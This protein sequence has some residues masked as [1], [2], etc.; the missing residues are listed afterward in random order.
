MIMKD[1]DRLKQNEIN[2]EQGQ[3]KKTDGKSKVS[4]V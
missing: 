1:L 2:T 4:I 3:K